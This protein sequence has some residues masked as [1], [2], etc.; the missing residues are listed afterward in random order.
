MNAPSTTR[1]VEK[2]TASGAIIELYDGANVVE[3]Q[4]ASGAVVASYAHGLGIDEPLAM[5]RGGN[6]EY[7]QADGL[8]T[9][10]SLTGSR[11]QLTATCGYDSFGNT[12]PTEGIFNPYRYTAREQAPETG[13]PELARFQLRGMHLLQGSDHSAQGKKERRRLEA[14][15]EWLQLILPI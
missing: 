3:E 9:I 2:L 4:I 7:F 6:V 12:T 14:G 11:G 13:G 1:R 10:T 8:G 5:Q 15:G